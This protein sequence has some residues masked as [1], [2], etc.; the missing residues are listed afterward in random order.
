[1]SI[2]ATSG[3]FSAMPGGRWTKP[4]AGFPL[5][6]PSRSVLDLRDAYQVDLQEQG[7]L[8]GRIRG[9]AC[10]LV[11]ERGF[12]LHQEVMWQGSDVDLAVQIGAATLPA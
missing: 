8:P 12:V 9:P 11:D 7:R 2:P 3:T 1:M 4:R 5:A 10:T 6:R